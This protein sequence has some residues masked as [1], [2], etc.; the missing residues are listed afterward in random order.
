MDNASGI[1]FIPPDTLRNIYTP[2]A[3]IK[4]YLIK[5]P[6]NVE[7]DYFFV[8]INTPKK[9]IVVNDLTTKLGKGSHDVLTPGFSKA[10]DLIKQYDNE[11]KKSDDNELKYQQSKIPNISIGNCNNINI[12]IT[13]KHYQYFI[14]A[15]LSLDN[16]N[17][18]IIQVLIKYKFF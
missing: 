9:Y 8:S 10:S 16:K 2:V 6:N 5:R 11:E 14:I 17:E 3:D 4:K 18:I 1:S 15:I 7:D 13:F 12:N